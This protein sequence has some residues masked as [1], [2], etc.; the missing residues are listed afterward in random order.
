MKEEYSVLSPKFGG[1]PKGLGDPNDKSLRKVE[2][3]VLI[4]KLMRERT[5]SE[6]CVAEVKEFHNCC[7]DSG[8]LHVIK[9]RKENDRMKKCMERWYYDQGFIKECTEQYL[10]ERSEFRRTGIPKNKKY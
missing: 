5:K 8:L 10:E 1:G 2:K 3:D 7:L 6:K 4:P 9:C